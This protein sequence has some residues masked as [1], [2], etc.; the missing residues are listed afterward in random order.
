MARLK[1][2][3]V[4]IT[5]LIIFCNTF[6][7]KKGVRITYNTAEFTSTTEDMAAAMNIQLPENIDS[8]K[9]LYDPKSLNEKPIEL[10]TLLVIRKE[11]GPIQKIKVSSDTLISEF[12]LTTKKGAAIFYFKSKKGDGI[13]TIRIEGSYDKPENEFSI[14]EY[15]HTITGNR[16]TILGYECKQVMITEIVTS[17]IDMSKQE[18]HMNAWVTDKIFPVIPLQSILML[19]TDILPEFTLLEVI[20]SP[21]GPGPHQLVASELKHEN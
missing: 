16:R 1:K 12:D 17:K 13:D 5:S 6:A 11:K 18:F 21:Y 14:Y 19:H 2:S 10:A 8:L 15:K 4:L 7:Q 20:R 3:L 9:K